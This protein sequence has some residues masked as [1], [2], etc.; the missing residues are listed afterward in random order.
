MRV[1]IFAII[2]LS[3][4]ACSKYEEGSPSFESKKS[5]LVNNWTVVSITANGFNITGLN[6][7]TGLDVNANNTFTV[8]SLVNGVTVGTNS[9]WIFDG[10]KKNILVTNSDG[11]LDSY[12][13]VKLEKDSMKLR[14]VN[15]SGVTLLH[16]YKS[17]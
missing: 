12:E 6:L 10:Q 11:S 2:A 13:I 9:T 1:L 17:A 8:Y 7:I 3:L 14:I 5:R 16:E 15:S 4:G